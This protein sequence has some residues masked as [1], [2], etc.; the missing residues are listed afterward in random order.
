MAYKGLAEFYYAEVDTDDATNG[1]KYKAAPV[2]LQYPIESKYSEERAEGQ[3]YAGDALREEES[4][5]AKG[6]LS[7]GVS[8]DDDETFA[9]LLGNTVTSISV[10][11]GDGAET[12]KK[13]SVGGSDTPIK[14]GFAQIVP[15]IINGA[16]KYKV[17]FFYM[18]KFAPGDKERSTKNGSIEYK[19]P[20]LE[21]TV[22]ENAKGKHEEHATFADI[23][24]ART[25]LTGLF[26]VT[27]PGVD[28]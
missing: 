18:V 2:E 17:E 25:F 8:H 6:T 16:K 7:I 26:P 13:I 28:D 23:A 21:G 9:K 14:V 10:G 11:S 1:T 19:T 5:F 20:S 12:V 24:N 15:I 4:E 27:T 3:L 22:F